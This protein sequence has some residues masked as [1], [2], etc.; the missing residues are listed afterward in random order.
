MEGSGDS[1][2]SLSPWDA[3]LCP[4]IVASLLGLWRG[5]GEE[6]LASVSRIQAGPPGDI[7]LKILV[8]LQAIYEF[9]LLVS[10]PF[11]RH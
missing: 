3:F 10:L 7:F 4:K 11:K 2:S 5:E 1:L 8:R 6:A 9:D